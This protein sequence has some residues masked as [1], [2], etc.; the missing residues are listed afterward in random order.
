ME[1]PEYKYSLQELLCLKVFSNTLEVIQS[2]AFC[3]AVVTWAESEIMSG[4]NSETLLILASLG[5]DSV[6]DNFEVEKY[7]LIYQREQNI[8]N[9]PPHFSALVW[10][11]LK[12]GQLIASSSA[13]E[14]ESRLS[15]FTHYFLDYPPRTFARITNVLSSFYWEL[16]DEA[17]PVFSS[18]AS[19]MSEDKLLEQVK[20]RLFPFYRILNNPD[21]MQILAR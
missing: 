13:Y 10:L 9:P 11:R 4:T 12:L 19:E 7:L 8:Q 6:L 1:N 17:I 15:F 18:K 2:D 16:Y 14:V 21:W 3:R 20:D 5:L